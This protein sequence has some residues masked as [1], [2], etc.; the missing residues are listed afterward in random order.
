[1]LKK[2]AGILILIVLGAGSVL[3]QFSSNS[4]AD[5]NQIQQ[6][7]YQNYDGTVYDTFEGSYFRQFKRWEMHWGPRLTGKS[8]FDVASKQ[9][10]TYVRNF[11]Q[12]HRESKVVAS[13]WAEL[14]PM[15]NGQG[16]I[17]R[18][19]AIAFH[20]TDTNTIY[21]GCPSGGVWASYNRGLNWQNLNTDQ[22]LPALGVSSIAVDASD[23]DILFLGT[24]DVDS[25]YVF[26]NG[27][28]RSED[29]GQTWQPAGLN[30]LDVHFTIA[31]VL[32]H[33]ENTDVAFA[34]TSLG[35][36]KSTNRNQQNPAWQ[37][38]YPPE[39]DDFEYIRNIAFHPNNP[40]IM[41]ATGIDIISST[42]GGVYGSWQRIAT[43][44]NGLDFENTPFPNVFNGEEFVLSLNMALAPQGDYLY[45]N[46]VS[47]DGPPPH[48]WQSA[49]HYHVF[50][51]DIDDDQWSEL[52]NSLMHGAITAGR[53]E[54]AV[55]PENSNVLY[56]AGVR[57]KVL[58]TDSLDN[59]WEEVDF[60]SHID[61]HELLFSPWEENVLYAGTDGGLYKR[62]LTPTS[63]FTDG[64]FSRKD[65]TGMANGYPCIELN[66]GLGIATIY[67]FGSSPIDPYQILTGTQDCGINYFKDN[68][69]RIQ[70]NP[71]DGFQC[72]MD[73]SDIG[74]MYATIYR[75]T[76]G[77]LWRSNYDDQD[78]H[79]HSFFNGQSP[80]NEQSWFGASLVADPTNSRTLFQARINLWKVDDASSATI[81]DWYKITDVS[82]LT[83]DLWGN[84]NCV[85]YALEIAP[86]N[87][88]YI[89]FSG[90][91]VDS[92]VTDFD[93]NRIFKTSTG[94]GTNA[95]DWT[96]ITPPTPGNAIGTY[97]ISDIAVSSSDPEKIW[98]SYSG[99]L[100]D[101]KIKHYD[102][103]G[104]TDY[105]KGLP[106]IPV[107]CIVYVL[108]SN[109]A[110]FIGTDVGVYYRDAEMEQWEPFMTNLPNVIVNWLEVNYTNQKL[111]A[112]TFGRG[113]WESDIPSS[114]SIPEDISLKSFKAFPTPGSAKTITLGFENILNQGDLE[115][116][117]YNIFGGVMLRQ[118]IKAGQQNVEISIATWDTGVYVAV[119]F[120]N[121]KALGKVKFVVN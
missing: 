44:N 108:G 104:W 21:V 6:S 61:F 33:P 77:S 68:I 31:K 119:I 17:G 71:N 35:I 14:G 117:C 38:V 9:Y 103:T 7:F 46:C 4:P 15:K 109:D 50:R 58:D 3:C 86:G 25:E 107:N 69:W 59:A 53:T 112:G 116:R 85:T 30:D 13:N 118:E 97:F 105:N 72:L 51:Y 22:Q 45:V 54:M 8:N 48:N 106:N 11:N 115:L 92:W 94:G 100:E 52:S 70:E 27:I 16:G 73:D 110:L 18:I 90:I 2:S 24:G 101:Y 75:P 102:G 67:N 47:R 40:E 23:P 83:S 114:I 74:L 36:Y 82:T 79:W 37:K 39:A 55:S 5:F 57:I 19:D 43:A 62:N 80:V 65:Y 111:R 12:L 98:I 113:L 93:A 10:N 1:M 32:L 88:E 121:G 89:Y 87:P 41:Y 64:G 66:N 96:E 60:D 29:A 20:P 63:H 56:S 81:D 42:G 120:S 99:Y 95:D 78:P 28:Y 76:N 49:T 34:A 84:N 26:S 91:K